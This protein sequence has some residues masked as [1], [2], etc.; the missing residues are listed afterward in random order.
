MSG[1]GLRSRGGVNAEQEANGDDEVG[2]LAQVLLDVLGVVGLI[3]GLQVLAINAQLGNGILHALPGAGVEGFVIH[4]AQVG[5][6]ADEEL[7][8]SGAAGA[9]VGAGAAGASV[10]AGAV[11]QAVNSIEAKSTKA[12]IV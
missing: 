4:A 8:V 5:D 9:V 6:L 7:G 12:T 1:I 2:V 3:L 11:P 10:A